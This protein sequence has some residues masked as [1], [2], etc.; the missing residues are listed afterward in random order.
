MDANGSIADPAAVAADVHRLRAQ[1]RADRQT[2]TAPMVIFGALILLHAVVTVASTATA[3]RHLVLLVYWPL[4]GAVGLLL[5]WRHAHRLAAR[6]GVG[7]G[8]RSYKPIAL[9]YLVSLPVIAVLFIP[10]LLLGVFAPLLWPAVIFTAIRVRQRSPEL[11]TVATI[12]YAGGLTQGLL[13]LVLSQVDLVAGWSVLGVEAALGCGLLV[14]AFLLA[15]RA[16]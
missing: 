9:G 15:R 2:V 6:E 13:T 1:V 7:E 11:R 4:A 8:R 5:L 10:V 14:A 3:L 16:R 12:L